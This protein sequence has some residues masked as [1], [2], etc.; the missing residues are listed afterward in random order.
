PLAEMFPHRFYHLAASRDAA[1]SFPIVA[2]PSIHYASPED[3]QKYDIVQSIRTLT[4]LRQQHAEKRSGGRLHFRSTAEMVTACKEHSDW[5]R[6]THE[7]AG[8][9]NFDLPF[10]K[11]Q[12]PSF[13]PPD[14]SPPGDFLRR[15][16]LQ[17]LH[18]RYGARADKFHPQVME[19]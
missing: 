14:N 7:I 19:E 8:R 2:C 3:R 12:F 11:P 4:L 1:S 15:L 5:L 9:C 16:V 13:V 6:H 18:E 17:G 10:G